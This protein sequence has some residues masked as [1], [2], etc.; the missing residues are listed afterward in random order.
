M[1]G[2]TGKKILMAE[3]AEDVDGIQGKKIVL[4][5]CGL[6]GQLLCS[7]STEHRNKFVGKKVSSEKQSTSNRLMLSWCGRIWAFSLPIVIAYFHCLWPLFIAHSSLPIGH[8]MFTMLEDLCPCLR[9]ANCLCLLLVA[10]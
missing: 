8:R 4:L 1:L 10:W 2:I 3:K 9:V 6:G 5:A 7:T